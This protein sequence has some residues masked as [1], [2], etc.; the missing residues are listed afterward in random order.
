M[1]MGSP[2]PAVLSN[3]IMEEFES[4]ALETAPHPPK[5]WATYVEDTGVILKQEH[6]NEPFEQINKQHHSIKFTIEKENKENSLPMLDLKLIR[7]DKKIVTDI[8]RKPT[9]TDHNLQ[10]SS[11]HPVHQK[12]GIVRT[13]MNRANTLIKDE[14]FRRIEKEKV[15]VALRRCG[16]PEWALKEGDIQS[17]KKD[18]NKEGNDQENET[19][20]KGIA[21][22][23]YMKGV[24]ERLQRAYRKHG[25]S[26]YS[27]AGYTVRNAVVRPKD[28]LDNDEQ[29]GVIYE[30]GCDNCG[31]KYI[32]ETGRSL[33]ERMTEHGKSV[34]KC[35]E[36]SALCQHQERTGHVVKVNEIMEK[37]KVVDRESR[38]QHRKVCEAIHIRLKGPKMNRN[39]GADLPDIYLPLLREED[40]GGASR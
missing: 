6:E 9:H 10:W 35:D 30:C 4:K 37:V 13:L 24:S 12:I 33:G 22:L 21:V 31:D 29:C 2:L 20:P 34:M 36:S 8:Y 16:Y 18:Q 23:P 5:F 19:R 25:I 32:G 15:K 3:L 39:D 7:K 26:M 27:K 11:H 40:G 17:K 28:P 1:A 14:H 38:D